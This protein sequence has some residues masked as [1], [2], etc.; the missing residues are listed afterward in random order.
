[1]RLED[2]PPCRACDHDD[3]QEGGH[4]RPPTA[5]PLGDPHVLAGRRAFGHREGAARCGRQCTGGHDA[6]RHLAGESRALAGDTRALACDTRALACDT[7]A[8]ACDTRALACDTRAFACDTRALACDTRAL[9]C[10]TRALDRRDGTR[11]DRTG[12]D[13]ASCELARCDRTGADLARR[14]LARCDRNGADLARCDLAGWVLD[15]QACDLAR[16]RG[17][18]RLTC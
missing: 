13:L 16:D 2:I 6:R 9:A 8:L 12:A 5:A 1:M 4:P 15:R 17:G 3:D 11:C 7:R 10:D 18:D 14:N